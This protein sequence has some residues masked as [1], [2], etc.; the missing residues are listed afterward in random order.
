MK[1]QKCQE[2]MLEVNGHIKCLVCG[3]ELEKEL[4]TNQDKNNNPSGKG[5]FGEHPE[6]RS[7]GRWKKEDS[8]TY[9]LSYFKTLDIKD[10][11]EWEKKNKKRTMAQVAAYERMA[12]VRNELREFQE[13][14]N[15]TEGMPKQAL[16]ISEVKGV[17]SDQANIYDE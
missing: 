2:E 1:C 7:D 17:N 14:A 11:Q 6:N 8:F 13:V 12:R 3:K 16:E 10:F 4:T 15:R 9:W 5:G